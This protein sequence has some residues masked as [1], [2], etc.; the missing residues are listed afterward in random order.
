MTPSELVLLPYPQR[1]DFTGG[2]VTLPEAGRIALPELRG[3]ELAFAAQRAQAALARHARLNWPIEG[4]GPA[5]ALTFIWSDHLLPSEG[6]RLAVSDTGI[7]ITAS[8]APGAFYAVATLAQLLQ[9]HGRTLPALVI[10][11]WPDFP[12]RGVMLDI[13]RDKVPAME[14]LYHLVDLLAGWKV[15]QLQLYTEHTF[16]YA[17]HREVW[18]H[19]SPMTAEQ[20]RALDAYCRDR[21]IELVPNQNSFGHMHRWFDHPRYRALAE[22]ETPFR[23]PWG[24][25]LPPF[26]LSPAA[27]GSLPFLEELFDELLPNFTSKLFNAGCDETFDLGLGRSRELVEARGKGR[28]YLD[29]LLEIY[30]LVKQ[31][32]RTM[33]FWG[34]IINQYPELVPEVPK[35]TIALEWGYEANHDFEGKTRLF[36]ES[37]VPFYVCPGTSSWSSFA[38]RADNCIANIRSAAIHGLEHGA[39][40]LLNTDWGDNGHWQP[41][42][43]SYLGFACGAALSWAYS[44]NVDRDLLLALDTFAFQDKARV[45]GRIAYDLGNLYQVSDQWASLLFNVYLRPLKPELR[46]D[47]GLR[48]RLR[49][50]LGRIDAIVEPLQQARMAAPDAELIQRE[51]AHVARLLKHGAK[52]ALFQID[53]S[54]FS[55]D[56]L[57]REFDELVA[58]QRE[59]WLRRNRPGG[60]NDS[61]ARLSG[62]RELLTG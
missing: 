3:A 41:L 59:I 48:A 25:M 40:G 21:C 42:P 35:D 16:A 23:A 10:D 22:T 53:N 27:P 31:R 38:G 57:A 28:V 49:D 1:I 12:A 62:A 20:I 47:E 7:T 9:T 14:T 33:L 5:A 46:S 52:R 4:E 54:E 29:F 18:E 50:A 19:A 37:G 30:R 44:A 6:Y 56:D 26:S 43:V 55:G 58:E 61:I 36:A 17:G 60:L 45:M 39:I 15:N 13:S 32:G 51:F 2:S 24:T 34:D 8:A 11:D